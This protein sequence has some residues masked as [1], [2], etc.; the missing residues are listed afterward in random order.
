[1]KKYKRKAFWTKLG[2]WIGFLISCVGCGVGVGFIIKGWEMPAIITLGIS[3]MCAVVFFIIAIVAS[4]YIRFK[5]YERKKL[6]LWVYNGASL[7][8]LGKDEKVLDKAGSNWGK[9]ELS[10]NV[11]GNKIDV[12]IAGRIITVKINGSLVE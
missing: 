9:C 8:V 3:S 6:S 7:C 2:W 4:V 11:N 5:T 10:A 12:R 1:M